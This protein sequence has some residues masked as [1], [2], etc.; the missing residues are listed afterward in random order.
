VIFLLAFIF[1]FGLLIG[2]FLNALI[3]RTHQERSINEKHSICPHC[4]HP[5]AWYDLF[6]VIS[7]LYLRGQCRYCH[8]AISWEYPIVEFTTAVLFVVTSVVVL[9]HAVNMPIYASALAFVGPGSSPY[10]T[11]LIASLLDPWTIASLVFSL[12]VAALLIALFIYDYH[13]QLLPDAWNYL[14]SG[15]A[16][17]VTLLASALHKPLLWQPAITAPTLYSSNVLLPTLLSGLLAATL[18]LAIVYG[19]EKILHKP[20]MGI[21][22]VKL[23]AFMG[24]WLGFP[25]IVVALYLA[26]ILGAVLSLMLLT[27]KRKKFGQAI[28]F[29]PFMVA[30]TFLAWWIAPWIT[31]WYQIYL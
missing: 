20:G 7:F 10:S 23:A 5:L 14:G 1:V 11:M 29:G 12:F 31:A 26:F 18:F 24:L 15:M 8:T 22:D 9:L 30:G 25:G 19:S 27:T 17:G 2:S 28:A 13:W 4:S 6:P 16:I 3:W 21:G